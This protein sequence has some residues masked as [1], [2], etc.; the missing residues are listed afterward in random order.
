[1]QKERLKQV[2]SKKI[3][4]MRT[5]CRR[6][7]NYFVHEKMWMVPVWGVNNARV[8]LYY[9]QKCAPSREDALKEADE[10]PGF[11]GIYNVD[12]F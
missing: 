10:Q 3:W 1:M 12:P 6:C 4:F 7:G 8:E 11:F 5:E 9:C 2:K